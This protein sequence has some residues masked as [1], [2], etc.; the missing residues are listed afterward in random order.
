[1]L[2][3]LKKNQISQPV[4]LNFIVR[5][6]KVVQAG[7]SLSSLKPYKLKPILRE[8]NLYFLTCFSTK[9]TSD[10]ESVGREHSDT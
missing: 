5:I 2:K 7:T 10:R 4:F 9:E 1:M 3:R 6:S 8:N